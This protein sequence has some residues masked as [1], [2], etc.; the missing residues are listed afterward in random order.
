MIEMMATN[1]EMEAFLRNPDISGGSAIIAPNME[2]IAGPM[3][4]EEGILYADLDL[5]KGIEMKLRHDFVGH[6]NRPDIFQLR[7]NRQVPQI[8]VEED[9]PIASTSGDNTKADPDT[10]DEADVN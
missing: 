7:I 1:E 9:T 6:Y 3:G 10:N 2:V 8:F 5:E 4:N